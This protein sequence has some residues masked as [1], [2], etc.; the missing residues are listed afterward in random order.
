ME[1]FVK[2]CYNGYS[3]KTEAF[4]DENKLLKTHLIFDSYEKRFLRSRIDKPH[5]IPTGESERQKIIEKVKTMLGYDENLIPQIENLTEVSEADL[6]AFSVKH[7]RYTTWKDTYA[8]ASLYLPKARRKL[9]LALLACGHGAG[10]RLYKKYR[11]MA[12]RLAATGIAVIVPDNI[13]QGD[14]EFMGHKDCVGPF[15]AGLTLQGLIV[16]E[17][18]ALIRHMAKDERF[19]TS[20][21]AALG[22]SG[23]G[24]LT[25]MLAA[26]APELSVIASSGYPSEFHYIFSKE[27]GHC[28]CNLLPGCVA[29]DMWEIYSVFA[30]KPLL[31]ESGIHDKYFPIEYFERNARRVA[32]VYTLKGA[33]ESFEKVATDTR[34]GWEDEDYF[35]ISEFLKRRLGAA[36]TESS[37]SVKSEEDNRDVYHVSFP[38]GALTTDALA[39]MLC[40]KKMPAGTALEDIFKPTF[41][42][43]EIRESEIISDLGR[44]RVMKAFAQMECALKQK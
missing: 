28:S 39:E 21:F 24:T 18:V 27:R 32:G 25:M 10:G 44:G 34:H 33:G 36:E 23:G 42:G 41:C 31:L 2:V 1:I 15:F 26:L 6:G 29:L 4:M 37:E 3:I 12:R 19:D 17:T 38:D 13:G 40:G 11:A 5:Y 14:R 7:L 16:M 20:R 9:P 8:S 30:P 22:N 43:E 35:V